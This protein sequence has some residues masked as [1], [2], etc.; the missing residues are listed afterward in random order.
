MS[1]FFE[2]ICVSNGELE[3]VKL[4]EERMQRARNEKL[5]ISEPLTLDSFRVP[6]SARQ[7]K[8]KCRVEY[9]E[10]ID[11]VTFEKYEPI[12]YDRFR[13]IDADSAEYPHKFTDRSLLIEL[14]DR[15]APDGF[16]VVKNGYITDTYH[17]NLVFFDGENWY[18]SRT[19]LLRGCMREHLIRTGQ[20][21][22][23]TIRPSDL[24][25]FTHFKQINSM[26][27]FEDSPMMGIERII[28]SQGPAD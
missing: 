16:I 12:G 4:H 15:I 2:S 17:A 8:F 3:L 27:G 18:T 22:L 1:L 28:S 5:G 6:I 26:L 19:P 11:H 23:D 20:V 9:G 25:R 21:A 13:L 14:L 24:S 10:T 7:G